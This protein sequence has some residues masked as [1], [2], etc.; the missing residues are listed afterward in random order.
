MRLLSLV[1][2]SRTAYPLSLEKER[3]EEE[4]EEEAE[5]SFTVQ[6]KITHLDGKQYKAVPLK[7]YF[8]PTHTRAV[9][10]TRP[11]RT[12]RN[13]PPLTSQVLS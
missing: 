5:W 10:A 4:E 7:T 3:K 9:S 6:V 8:K 1:R 12:E 13:N 2:S 11:I